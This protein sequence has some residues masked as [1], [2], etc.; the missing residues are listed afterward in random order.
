M[1]VAK[2]YTTYNNKVQEYKKSFNNNKKSDKEKRLNKQNKSWIRNIKL[3]NNCTTQN[4]ST[5][6]ITQ[7]N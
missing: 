2:L 5:K 3:K 6:L 7:V 1:Y 4:C